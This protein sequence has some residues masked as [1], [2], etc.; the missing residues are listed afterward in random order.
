MDPTQQSFVDHMCA[1]RDAFVTDAEICQSNLPL[2]SEKDGPWQLCGPVLLLGTAGTGKTTTM[3]AVNQQLEVHGLKGRIV[4][5]AYTGVAASNMGSG[6]RTIMSLF[7]L[8]TNRKP[9]PLQPLSEDDMQS[10]AAEL[11]EMAVLELDE[12]SM[13]EKVVLAHIHLRLQQW[14]F[15][16]YHPQWCER[17][18]PCRCGARLPF[19]G[20]KV[21]LAGDFG[22]LP[23]V[24]VKDE[25]T[26]L[27]GIV[28]STGKD[29]MEVNLGSR[30][31]RSISNVFRLRRI[32]RQAGASQYKES[33]L[34]LR[35]AAH[36]KED[37]ALWKSHDMTSPDCTLSAEEIRSFQR[38]RVHLFCEKHRAGA[39]NG[40]RLGE[41]ATVADG[42]GILRVWSV[43][44]SSLVERHYCENFGGLRRVLHFTMGAPV[45]L[46]SNLRTVWNLVNG[47]RGRI[48]GLGGGGG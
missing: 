12:L 15:A 25:K 21:V 16:C 41:D 22:Q 18:S 27:N 1:W 11:G 4:R 3:Q 14:R 20:V 38:D 32:H 6:A 48:V 36:T 43:E 13:I 26:L 47:L 46:I 2:P 31:F 37:V 23:P 8:K 19:G 40:R 35:D 17:S 30:L 45:M 34:R 42:S 9:E 28:Q 5:A 7:R 33:L 10:M 39:F 29:A 44:S 24:A